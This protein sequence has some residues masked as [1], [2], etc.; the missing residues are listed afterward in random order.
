A[1]CLEDLLSKEYAKYRQSGAVTSRFDESL[2][3][4]VDQTV[5]L[6]GRTIWGKLA[7]TVN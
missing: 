4:D 7:S 6:K 3:E 1:C 5:Y 2:C